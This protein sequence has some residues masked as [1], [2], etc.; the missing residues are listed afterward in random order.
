MCYNFCSRGQLGHGDLDDKL[1]PTLIDALAGLK[2][3]HI[4]A[5]GWHSCALSQDKVLYTWGWN[6]NGQ[7]GLAKNEGDKT[8]SV[9]ATP[10]L[11]DINGDDLNVFKVAA[12]TRH[13]IVLLG[14]YSQYHYKYYS[15]G[16][17]Y[18]EVLN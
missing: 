13:T 15:F 6:S 11:I 8:V 16:N 7:L 3:S 5:G 10:Q 18:I 12:G 2:I 1:E 17:F 4:A 9:M 14:S